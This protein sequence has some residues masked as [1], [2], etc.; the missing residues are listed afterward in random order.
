MAYTLRILRGAQKQLEEL[1]EKD[2]RIVKAKILSLTDNPRPHGCEK[3]KNR[4]GYR[5][6]QRNYRIIYDIYD[7][8][9]V[10]EVLRIGDRKDVY[11]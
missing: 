5:I 1:P 4:V 9:L 2:Y 7:K 10:V 11:R 8:I 3:L 6:R